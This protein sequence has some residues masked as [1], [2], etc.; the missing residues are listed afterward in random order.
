M[1]K[2]TGKEKTLRGT[3][4]HRRCRGIISAKYSTEGFAKVLA[5][6]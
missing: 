2:P 6:K 5:A 4:A 3:R 1:G